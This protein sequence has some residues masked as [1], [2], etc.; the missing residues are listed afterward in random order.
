MKKIIIANWKAN[1]SSLKE[2]KAIVAEQKKTWTKIKNCK[3]V[4]CPPTPFIGLLSGTKTVAWGAQDMSIGFEGSFTGENTINMLKSVGVSYVILGHSERKAV[5]ETLETVAVK[6]LMA[7][8]AGLT[9]IVCV[10]EES[11]DEHGEFLNKLKDQITTIFSKIA[12]A[13]IAKVIVAYEPIWAIGKSDTG[14]IGERELH[15]ST[16][17][18]RK[19]LSDMCG[20]ANADKVAIVYG[21]SVSSKNADI[22]LRTGDVAGLLIGRDSLT[23]DFSEILLLAEHNK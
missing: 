8:K 18:I 23:K 10:G 1:P 11:R 22:F 5:G 9:P 12:K 16:I 4:I 19:V 2:A 3:I 6:V 14:A 21:G 15:E 17:F 13:Q 20:R 7:I